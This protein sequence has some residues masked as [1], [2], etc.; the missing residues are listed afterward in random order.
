MSTNTIIFRYL[1][2]IATI[3]LSV[4]AS[5]QENEQVAK[6]NEGV[7]SLPYLT[8]GESV[9]KGVD[10]TYLGDL[11]FD[12]LDFDSVSTEVRETVANLVGNKLTIKILAVGDDTYINLDLQYLGG[13]RLELRDFTGPLLPLSFS[14]TTFSQLEP[15]EWETTKRVYNT[16][17]NSWTNSKSNLMTSDFPTMDVDRD[18]YKDIIVLGVIWDNGWVDKKVRIRWLRNTG[19]GELVPGDDTTFPQ[20]SSRVHPRYSK[21]ADFNGD[22]FDD[23]LVMAHGFDVAP[24]EGESN[25]L[26][27][28]QPDGTFFDASLNNPNFDYFG[29][30]HALVVGDVNNDGYLD[31]ITSDIGGKDIVDGR[32]RILLNDGLGNFQRNDSFVSTSDGENPYWTNATLNLE[33]FDINGDGFDDLVMGSSYIFEQDRIFLNDKSGGFDYRK[34]I[35]LPKFYEKSG[36]LLYDTLAI[37]IMDLNFDGL[38]D[39]VF[40]KSKDYKGRAIQFLI[41]NG[42]ESFTDVTQDYSPW[43]NEPDFE[44][45]EHAPYWIEAADM[46]GD[47]YKDLLLKYDQYNPWFDP[48]YIWVRDGLDGFIEWDQNNLTIDNAWFWVLDTDADGDLDLVARRPVSIDNVNGFEK[49]ERFEWKILEN[50]ILN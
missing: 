20:T 36:R 33:L 30:T 1:C 15:E 39:L 13:V 34:Y 18:G 16:N 45:S 12:V 9:Y 29:F 3:Q 48:R 14:E 8:F 4:Y 22:G 26:L 35:T 25:L 41:N 10:L 19:N 6:Y 24:Y 38:D 46:N 21:V 37:V 43:V 49:D 7:V 2:F 40:S 23:L 50:K 42:D 28:S 31:I 11:K 44:K 5:A 32:T 17:T 47:G 27:L